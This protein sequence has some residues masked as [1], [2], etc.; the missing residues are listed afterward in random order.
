VED[1]KY[2]I[3]DFE[4]GDEVIL[5]ETSWA[6][7]PKGTRGT[8]V[9]RSRSAPASCLTIK[10]HAGQELLGYRIGCADDGYYAWRFIPVAKAKKTCIYC[11]SL[12]E[13]YESKDVCTE[14]YR[15][16]EG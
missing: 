4:P 9:G 13:R 14:C 1:N 12:T 2:T 6:S 15:V 16:Q 8:V 7:L 11:G 10:W 5:V 3:E